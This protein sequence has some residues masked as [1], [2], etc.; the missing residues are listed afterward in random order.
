MAVAVYA[1]AVLTWSLMAPDGIVVFDDYAWDLMRSDR[2]RPELGIDA[3]LK[4]IEGL[5][6]EL[7]RDRQI[8]IENVW[9]CRLR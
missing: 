6:R 7:H 1:D 3:S 2:Q 5:Y 4:T 9:D 8:V